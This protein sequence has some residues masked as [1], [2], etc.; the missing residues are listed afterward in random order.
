VPEPLEIQYAR[1]DEQIKA[2]RQL[3]EGTRFVADLVH[4]YGRRLAVHEER[5]NELRGDL[6]GLDGRLEAS[7]ARLEKSCN[8]L[9]DLIRAQQQAVSRVQS[10]QD[11]QTRALTRREKWL[12]MLAGVFAS[13]AAGLLVNLLTNS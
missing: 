10:E 5:F 6:A 4:D 13:G 11:Q 9:G 3:V 8:D 7:V 12:V 2:L 1:L